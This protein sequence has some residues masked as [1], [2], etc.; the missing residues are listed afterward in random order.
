MAALNDELLSHHIATIKRGAGLGNQ[1][2][3]YLA[4]MKAIIRKQVAGF[5]AEKRTATRL[6][7]DAAFVRRALADLVTNQDLSR[8]V[9]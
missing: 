1:V 5:D 6:E 9:L 2:E 8:Y 3:P 7:I 4:E